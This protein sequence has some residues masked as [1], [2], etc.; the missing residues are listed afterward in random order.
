MNKSIK[1]TIETE[2]DDGEILGLIFINEKTI[3]L[4]T[5]EIARKIKS[6]NMPLFSKINDMTKLLRGRILRREIYDSSDYEQGKL[7]VKKSTPTKFKDFE[8]CRLLFEDN[9]LK[10]QGRIL[11][12]RNK[13]IDFFYDTLIV[14][15][16]IDNLNPEKLSKEDVDN[17]KLIS[18]IAELHLDLGP[19]IKTLLFKDCDKDRESLEKVS[20]ILELNV[21]DFFEEYVRT[22]S[23]R[24]DSSIE[25]L[26]KYHNSS[27]I[28]GN[29]DYSNNVFSEKFVNDTMRGVTSATPSNLDV[30]SE[31]VKGSKIGQ[32]SIN[33]FNTMKL[34]RSNVGEE[35]YYQIVRDLLPLSNNN[36][37]KILMT[38]NKFEQ[39]RDLFLKT[40]DMSKTKKTSQF[41]KIFQ[42]PKNSSNFLSAE[43]QVYNVQKHLLGYNIF[44]EK[45]SGIVSMTPVDYTNRFLAEQAKYYPNLNIEQESGFLLKK[46]KTDFYNNSS[47]PAYLTPSSLIFGKKRISTSRGV[48]NMNPDDF[49]MFRM[50]KTHLLIDNQG[51]QSRNKTSQNTMS[52]L[53]ITIEAPKKTILD[54]KVE[55][56]A[57][58]L[59][60]SRYYIGD[61][62]QFLTKDL[63]SIYKRFK[64]VLNK[65]DKKILDIVSSVVPRKFLVKNGSIKTIKDLQLSN[66]KSNIRKLISDKSIDIIKIPPQIKSMMSTNYSNSMVDPLQNL[67]LEPVISETQKNIFIVKALVGFEMEG[68]VPNFFRPI[69]TD[70]SNKLI[71]TYNR[72][73][74]AKAYDFEIPELGILKDNY[75]ATIYNNLII[76]GV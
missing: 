63:D 20:Y 10:R 57:D 74:I 76:I 12:T 62:S 73:M 46:E 50:A 54:R 56:S 11:T 60:D 41:S 31:S 25:F 67:E 58:P 29:Y 19:G 24:L 47:H 18:Q 21:S 70:L 17:G 38:L 14:S 32:A 64:T 30:S 35:V 22:I 1:F 53:N 28:L 8:V 43:T 3:S 5:S 49:K 39:A 65:E 52:R 16:T 6:I 71:E 13:P 55:E 45:H 75:A 26:K 61:S 9:R 36:P 68:G 69:Y 48:I 44:S 4:Q 23:K 33:Y 34:L 2:S 27:M 15:S 51:I 42:K 66:K 37:E 7:R 72:P 40:Y 59:I